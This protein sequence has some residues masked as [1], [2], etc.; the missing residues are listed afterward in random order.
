MLILEILKLTYRLINYFIF[1]KK[2]EF[3]KGKIIR[4]E[5]IL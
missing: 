1:N 5:Y 3:Y 4:I 2:Y